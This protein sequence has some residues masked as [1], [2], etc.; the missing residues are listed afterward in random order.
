[1]A[2]KGILVAV[3][4]HDIEHRGKW[5]CVPIYLGDQV[6]VWDLQKDALHGWLSLRPRKRGSAPQ[7]ATPQKS[8]ASEAR[9]TKEAGR[10][11]G[12]FL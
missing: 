12:I 6:L 5:V 3:G 11:P 10:Q 1:V 2:D 9:S 4:F 8:I 7:V